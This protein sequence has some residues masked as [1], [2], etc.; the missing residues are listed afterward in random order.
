MFEAATRILVGINAGAC[1]TPSTLIQSK[2][3]TFGIPESSPVVQT[4]RRRIRIVFRRP[5]RDDQ[6]FRRVPNQP[7]PCRR[8]AASQQRDL[9]AVR[10]ST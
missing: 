9:P 1:T 4:L 7:A 10:E 3:I 6:F 2:M 8:C 5:K